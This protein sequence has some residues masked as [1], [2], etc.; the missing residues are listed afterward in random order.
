MIHLQSNYI[1]WVGTNF[2]PIGNAIV[3]ESTF[4]MVSSS[5][6]VSYVLTNNSL[7]PISIIAD[8]KNLCILLGKY[9]RPYYIFKVLSFNQST[10]STYL[11]ST[12]YISF[13]T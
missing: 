11:M 9:K 12:G 3:S 2:L 5:Y 1:A 8:T 4:C 10:F 13:P 6:S 7:A